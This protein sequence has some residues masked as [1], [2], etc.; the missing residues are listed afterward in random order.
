MGV[1]FA[2]CEPR[3]A[4]NRGNEVAAAASKP[5]IFV[6]PPSDS[7]IAFSELG[8][9]LTIEPAWGFSPNSSPGLGAVAPW[10]GG[11]GCWER[12]GCGAAPSPQP[13][14]SRQAVIR[15]QQG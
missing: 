13:V 5:P 6:S 3:N 10:A 12:P 11:D 7:W 4:G 9:G 14:E 8:F 2:T 15:A 1:V